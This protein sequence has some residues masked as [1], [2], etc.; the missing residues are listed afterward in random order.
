MLF[1]QL[2][3]LLGYTYA[4]VVTA[5]LPGKSG[6]W[7]IGVHLVVL[8]G[9]LFFLPIDPPDSW[10]TLARFGSD[11]PTLGIL[12]L[13]S[14]SIGLPYFVLSTCSPLLQRWLSILSP[15]SVPYRLYALSNIG[16]LLALIGYPF[17]VEP[18]VSRKLQ[19]EIWSWCLVVFT[20]LYAMCAL[21]VS[22]QRNKSLVVKAK[23]DTNGKTAD[24]SSRKPL[25]F[26]F[27]ATASALLLSMT[28]KMCQEVAPIPLLWVVTLAIYLMTF[29]I[30]FGNQK[31]YSRKWY[32]I[33]FF[34]STTAAIAVMF[35]EESISILPQ[36]AVYSVMLFAG[37]MFCHGEVAR[38]KPRTE[39]LTSYYLSIASGGAL[40]GIFVALLAPIIFT[41]YF[42]FHFALFACCILTLTIFF[43]DKHSRLYRGKPRWAWMYLITFCVI[44]GVALYKQT[45]LIYTD[46]IETARNF[47]GA[48]IVS[49]F[50]KEDPQHRLLIMRHGKIVHGYQ[51]ENLRYRRVPTAYYGIQSGVG[52]VLMNFPKQASRRIGVVGLGVGTI[53]AYCRTGDYI[54]FYEI[55]PLV[56]QLAERDFSFLADCRGQKDIVIGDAR[57]SMEHEPSQQFDLLVLDAFNS[58]VPPLHL[59]TKESF[60]IY[61]KHLTSDGIIAVNISS[62]QVNLQK[63]LSSIVKDLSM[64]MVVLTDFDQEGD[65]A[66]MPSEWA[67]II[68][69]DTPAEFLNQKAIQE[70]VYP[71]RQAVS[72]I[73][74]WTDDYTSLYQVLN[75]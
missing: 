29:I 18:N 25:W 73:P 7:Q 65:V 35:F 2:L 52:R 19:A 17:L 68:N 36:V 8:L 4:H 42:E 62:K 54:R 49:E 71:S 55:N 64:P 23:D 31:W 66:R 69:R 58:E 67:L 59:L 50:N 75:W 13:L 11:N 34:V 60:Q 48:L 16:S 14:M 33:I 12:A 45:K 20:V 61:L 28:N 63:V 46:T 40:G 15:T 57:L 53:A 10:K 72:T 6:R 21:I 70:A 1:F 38:L 9:V 51:F 56:Q 24:G 74:V 26:I 27:P 41:G 47:Y 43:T 32:T 37:C 3:L 22:N 5:Y 30:S 44:V 39:H